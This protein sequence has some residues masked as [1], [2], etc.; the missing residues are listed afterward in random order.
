MSEICYICSKVI[1]EISSIFICQ[2][3]AKFV[4]KLLMKYPLIM[5]QSIMNPAAHCA[6]YITV[7]KC[8]T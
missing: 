7:Q 4:P 8:L 6:L 1:D 5:V 2:K 3:S